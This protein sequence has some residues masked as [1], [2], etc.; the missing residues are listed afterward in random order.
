L[1]FEF[2]A[3]FATGL[4]RF[5]VVT[6]AAKGEEHAIIRSGAVEQ[7]EGG[8]KFGGGNCKFLRVGV[9]WLRGGVEKSR[10]FIFCIFRVPKD[11]VS[12]DWGRGAI[13]REGIFGLP[14]DGMSLDADSETGIKEGAPSRCIRHVFN[15][16]EFSGVIRIGSAVSGTLTGKHV[17]S[18]DY[19]T[20]GPEPVPF[21]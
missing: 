21:G 13:F 4:Q 2:A 10:V 9:N 6:D 20:N 14:K 11:G 8:S 15:G 12:L 3:L 5:T 16:R 1:G 7:F 19:S 17:H 18:L